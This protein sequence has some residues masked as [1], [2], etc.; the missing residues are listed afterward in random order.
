MGDLHARPRL[1]DQV[2]ARRH[3]IDGR[4]CVVLH[5]VG[6]GRTVQVGAREW[7]LLAA[8]DGTRDVEGIAL[9]AAREG[10]R[11]RADDLRAFLAQ[12]ADAGFVVVGDAVDAPDPVGPAP[13]PPE[14]PLAVLA[15]FTL[16]C[17]GGGACCRQFETVL[18]SPVEVARARAT[19]PDVLDAGMQP[20]LGFLPER[21]AQ[22][23]GAS[24]V[25]LVDGA[26]A[27]LDGAMR[28]RIHAAGGEAAKPLGCRL[29]PATFVDDGVC[30][31]ISAAVECACVLASLGRDGGANLVPASARTRED[32]PASADIVRLPET[33]RL[34]ADRTA[35]AAELHA[36][37]A[38]VVASPAP[39]D[40]VAWLLDAADRI[41]RSGLTSADEAAAA[42]P[43]EGRAQDLLADVRAFHAGLERRAREAAT[44]RSERDFARQAVTWLERAT[45]TLLANGLAGAP[46]VPLDASREAFYVRAAIF[47]HA[48]ALDEDVPLTRA[49]RDR[50]IR[51]LLARAMGPLL[52]AAPSPIDRAL[53]EPIAVVDGTMRAQGLSLE[54]GRR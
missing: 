41:E 46:A 19:C 33:V 16:H 7:E 40:A 54:P 23:R 44:W 36:W 50:A 17:D 1:A 5:H 38:A 42:P 21:A 12:L 52:A 20:R 27:Y 45:A 14:R 39:A 29:F 53:R 10:G 9:A 49:L 25:A 15:G 13:C 37:S 6:S 30:V 34:T 48:L 28:C 35:S 2:V 11:A 4:A 32:L 3:V 51:L 22:R 47:G 24:A 31:R 8:A 26:C 43:A 18:F